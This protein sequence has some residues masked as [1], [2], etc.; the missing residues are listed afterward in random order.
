MENLSFRVSPMTPAQK[1]SHH[2]AVDGGAYVQY[3]H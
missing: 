3:L 2:G 1:K